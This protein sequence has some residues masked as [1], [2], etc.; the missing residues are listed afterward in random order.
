MRTVALL[1]GVILLAIGVASFVPALTPDGA[2]L[3]VLPMDTV[4][5]IL[6]VVT[7][8]A[9]IAIGLAH[10]H[11]LPPAPPGGHDMRSWM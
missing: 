9:G 6:F 1:L 4:R 7:G 3:G 2:L 10:R 8:L 11:E 5:G